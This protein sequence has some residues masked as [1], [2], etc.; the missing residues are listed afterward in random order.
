M[1][2]LE[3]LTINIIANSIA[4]PKSG[5]DTIII[6]CARRWSHEK[7]VTINI[8]T[9]EEGIERCQ[10][11]GLR[12]VNYVLWSSSRFNKLGL[13]PLYLFRI[14]K[15]CIAALLIPV[16]P[17]VIIMTESDFMPD[18]IPAWIMKKKI[19]GSKWI[20]GFYLFV[21]N[22]LK[23]TVYKGKRFFRGLFY[24]LSQMPIYYLVRKN[25]DMVFV[26]GEMDRWRFI[27]NKR[28]EPKDVLAIRG[29]IDMSMTNSVPDS[30]EKDF[31]AVFIGRF[32]P[33]KGVLELI[34][35]WKLVCEK[36]SYAKLA[37]IGVGELEEEVKQK[38]NRLN[39][40]SNISFLGYRD[41]VDKIR[42]FKRSRVVVHPAIYD[43]GGMAPCEAMACGLPAVSFDLPALKSYY[44][45][46][47]IKTPMFDLKAFACN[48]LALLEDEEEYRV[49]AKDALDWAEE[50]NWDKQ[51]PKI[52]E[53][54]TRAL[55]PST[56]KAT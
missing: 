30:K 46:G 44:P 9:T 32:H 24:F 3:S 39:L 52:F 13:Y 56:P 51:A 5:S 23:N 26:T 49:T 11:H 7:N 15:G 6:E 31:D 25:A 22:P 55:L 33:Q 21:Q 1:K 41:G 8:F 2:N 38:T 47:M 20:A 34:D 19:K 10:N 29:G 4:G 12:G 16:S 50:W 18:A 48:I 45:K 36:K 14:V 54:L 35:I 37:M 40:K 43:S 28:F 53:S 27:D 17:N 42:I